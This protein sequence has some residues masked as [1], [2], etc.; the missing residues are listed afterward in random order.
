MKV[1]YRYEASA[2]IVHSVSFLLNDTKTTIY[3]TLLT[4]TVKR[5]TDKGVWLDVYGKEKF[6]NHD[7]HKKY[8][9]PTVQEAWVSHQKRKLEYVRILRRQLEQAEAIVN[10][11]TFKSET[12]ADDNN[13][14]QFEG[15]F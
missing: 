9:C 12:P 6:V 3:Y 7:W 14:Y 2:D 15:Q 1:Y 4:F 10:H 5:E 13:R 8:A 11:P